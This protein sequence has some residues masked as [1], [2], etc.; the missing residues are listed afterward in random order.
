M[1]D[2][3]AISATRLCCEACGTN[4][5]PLYLVAT[6]QGKL[7]VLCGEHWE[8]WVETEKNEEVM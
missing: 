4:E 2:S 8:S 6:T 1:P 3:T 7:R 5:P